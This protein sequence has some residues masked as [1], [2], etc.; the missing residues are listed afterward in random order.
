MKK[1]CFI[2]VVLSLAI[3]IITF[4]V[5]SF[6]SIQEGT[7]GAG[8]TWKLENG[9]LTISGTGEMSEWGSQS[10]IPWFSL[11]ES[12]KN[13]VIE[14]GVLS[15]SKDAFSGTAFYNNQ[16][17]WENNVL[18]S[19][20]YL[21]DAR[22]ITDYTIKENTI[23][24]ADHA[25][26]YCTDLWNINIPS[27][28]KSIG[29]YA[30]NNCPSMRTIKL[31]EGLER[32][33]SNA[34]FGC[35]MLYSI[36]IPASVSYIGSEVFS[37]CDRLKSIT[38]DRNNMHYSSIDDVLFNKDRS[39]LIRYPSAKIR[40]IYY[41]PYSVKKIDSGAFLDCTEIFKVV[42]PRSVTY[43]GN[44]AFFGCV[45]MTSISIPLS[46]TQIGSKA[47]YNS[48]Y[49]KVQGNWQGGVLYI[50]Q[51]LIAAN[52]MEIC[53]I[54]DGTVCIA[55]DAFKNCEDLETV[56]IPKG[57]TTIGNNAFRGCEKLLS[58]NIPKGV[59]SIG[60]G[61]FYDCSGLMG[62]SIPLSVK[63]IGDG[64]FYGCVRLLGVFYA[65]SEAQW[66]MI[67]IGSYNEY[68]TGRKIYYNYELIPKDFAFEQNSKTQEEIEEEL[69]ALGLGGTTDMSAAIEIEQAIEN[70]R[71][72]GIGQ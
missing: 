30:F 43:I 38:V 56:S 60:A 1:R 39:V 44:N 68:M 23:C 15:I 62:I 50:D 12:I 31:P 58:I 29:K 24:I 66:K 25:F 10:D 32:I 67:K 41:I 61:A 16:S 55:D 4:P 65:G 64:A 18:Y 69:K 54:K 28:V 37:Y 53:T 48:G 59:S 35:R 27:S 49:Y 47:F 26:S 33:G 5:T 71:V 63:T 14:D 21:L 51:Y 8:L 72:E 22:N 17:N 70:D 2:A 3:M 19:G 36:S 42:I 20:R 11:R 45:N 6:A 7:C 46:V 52:N 57:V 40:E 13:V 9:T 34:F